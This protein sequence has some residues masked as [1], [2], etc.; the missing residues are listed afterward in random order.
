MQTDEFVK[1]TMED[2]LKYASMLDAH[3]NIFGS[4]SRSRLFRHLLLERY[5]VLITIDNLSRLTAYEN[6]LN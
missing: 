5:S 4:S 1:L 2:I 3:E 6:R